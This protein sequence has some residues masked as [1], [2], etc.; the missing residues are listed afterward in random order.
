MKK[1]WLTC[2]WIAF[3]ALLTAASAWGQQAP[4]TNTSPERNVK[5]LQTNGVS[6]EVLMPILQMEFKTFALGD[7]SI[8]VMGTSEELARAE[9]MIATLVASTNAPS[10][11]VQARLLVSVLSARREKA[12]WKVPERLQGVTSELSGLFPYQSFE[13]LDSVPVL[14]ST[15]NGNFSMESNLP[16]CS[17]KPEAEC[18]QLIALSAVTSKGTAVKVGSFNYRIQIPGEMFA[19]VPPEKEGAPA[20]PMAQRLQLVTTFQIGT[21]ETLV[22]GKLNAPSQF[23]AIFVVV[24]R[25][26]D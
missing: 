3:A 4:A 18:V 20:K 24:S 13:L 1:R 14:V 5:V 16:K 11:V 8:G 23:D 12:A 17:P 7:N 10:Q 15:D 19:G 6:T 9:R 21:G 22:L 25:L 26:K 2:R